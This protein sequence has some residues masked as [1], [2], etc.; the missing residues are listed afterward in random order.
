MTGRF[1]P[2]SLWYRHERERRSVDQSY[3][4]SEPRSLVVLGE[5]GMGKSTLLSQL[6]GLDG[7]LVCTAR[8]LINAPDAG[9]RFADAL[10][11]VVDALDEVPSQHQGDAVDLVVRKLGELGYPRFILSCRVADWRSATALQG[12]SEL[13]ETPPIE[14]HLEPLNRDDAIEFLSDSLEGERA[15]EVVDYLEAHGLAGLWNNPQTLELVEQV[16]LQ[17]QLPVSKGGLFE[18][19]TKILG[20]EHR[21]EKANTKLA[22][23]PHDEVLDVAGAAFAVLILTGKE[24]ISRRVNLGPEDIGLV[25]IAQLTTSDKIE[26]ILDSRLFAAIENDRFTY[27]HRAIGEFLGARWLAFHCVSDRKRR[28]LI[29]LFNGQALVPASLRG[30]HAWLS[31]HSSAL[32]GQVIETDPLGIVQ[33][34]DARQLKFIQARALLRALSTVAKDNP[35]F[36][37]WERFRVPGLARPELLP[38]I[39]E[40]I[41]SRETPH[42]LK[43][44]LFESL[45]GSSLIQQMAPTLKSILM[46]QSQV[47]AARSDAGELLIE[48][49]IPMNWT[50]TIEELRTQAGEDGVRLA[51]ELM[52][53]VGYD[54]FNDQ[55]LL[56][57]ILAQLDRVERTVGVFLSLERK[58]APE[59]IDAVLDGLSAAARTIVEKDDWEQAYAITDLAFGLLSRRLAHGPV[60][61]IEFWNWIEPFDSN[62][63]LRDESRKVVAE[64][65]S[66]NLEFKRSVQR[67]VLLEEP[68]EDNIW[69]RSWSLVR[70]S[71]ALAIEESDVL[72]LLDALEPGDMKWRELVLLVHHDGD[73]GSVIR[74]AAA[75][76]TVDDA[77]S[78]TWL[79]SLST[80]QVPDWQLKEEE[81][82]KKREA[83]RAEDW[84]K[85]RAN[86]LERIEE[87]R[88]GQY[89]TVVQPA[90]AYLK[91]FTD[92]GDEAIDGPGRIEEWL[93]VELREASLEGFEAFL[94]ATPVRPSASQL[95]DSYAEGRGWDAA[96]II[97]A[98]LAERVRTG[99]GFDDLPSERLM[100]GLFEL[101]QTRIDDH[102]GIAELDQQLADALRERDCWEEAQRLYFEPQFASKQAHISGLHELL[103][104]KRDSELSLRLSIEWLI[105]YPEMPN[106]LE[107][108]LLDHLVSISEGR[109]ALQGLARDRRKHAS[110][111]DERRRNWTAIG[112]IV[113][114]EHT[115]ADL[116]AK[117]T[118]EKELFPHIRSR[119]SDRYSNSLPIDLNVQQLIWLIQRFRRQYPVAQR[120]SGVTRGDDNPWDASEF[121]SGLISRLGDQVSSDA[122]EALTS[123]RDEEADGYTNMLRAVAA[124]QRRKKVELEW[125]SPDLNTVVSVVQDSAPTTPAQLQMILLEELKQVQAQLRG[126]DV[127]WYK[128][129]FEGGRPRVEDDCRDTLLKMLRPLP[130]EIQAL[131]EGHL[132]DDKRCDIICLLGDVMVPVEVKGQWHNKLWTAADQQ[133][134]RL[135]VNDWRADRGIYLVFWFGTES[136]KPVRKPPAGISPPTSAEEL[137]TNLTNFTSTT[138]E[139]RV[140]VVVLDLERP[141]Q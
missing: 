44:L 53:S 97:V 34:G 139:G 26:A 116:D 20:R 13:Y 3:L 125:T 84:A 91:M 61:A 36:L 104:D 15:R 72:V 38:E 24:A 93:G 136:S 89:G 9:S 100:A 94:N 32:A 17:G 5:A 140:E 106:S 30:I 56:D 40:L 68:G 21:E 22:A 35:W 141:S 80:P 99:R 14:L 10:T 46:D 7:Y 122:I 133:L 66:R 127:D 87:M 126:S 124:E 55:L 25:Q 83:K 12:F 128:D 123:L 43:L 70:R 8:A 118:V 75:R 77:E 113:D 59:R 57:V 121:I 101:W 67:L 78:V 60:S 37:G 95:A 50:S 115:S 119:V 1:L 76:F 86:Y 120:P 64:F 51:L 102:A 31:W 63:S 47:F 79:D 28:R 62:R 71:P 111:D 112:I 85:H 82:Q 74:D 52:G 114:F 137:R 65:L 73:R 130:F 29:E 96:A 2:R 27:T 109:S 108:Q 105:R 110:S 117:G 103:N 11:L 48:A 138:R 135:Y 16:A 19:A 18:E 4:S 23:L 131:P 90:K 41:I 107:V 33:Y 88:T 129:F 6:R 69:Q 39:T 58:L 98:A 132:A 49:D 92:V 54:Q 81:R 134:D 45:H 42:R